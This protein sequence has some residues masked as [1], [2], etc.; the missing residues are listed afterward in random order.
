MNGELVGEEKLDNDPFIQRVMAD[1]EAISREGIP[2]DEP[3]QPSPHNSRVLVSDEEYA[4]ARGTLR[5]R[6]SYDPAV[7]PYHVGDIVYLD[8]RAHQITGLRDD[9]VQLLPTGMSYPIY[10]PSARNSLSSF[11]G[12]ITATTSILSSC[13]QTWIR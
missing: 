13:L 11:F 8:D 12:Q 4:A 1:V 6:T 7:L 2:A 5:E 10:R 9:T 3:E